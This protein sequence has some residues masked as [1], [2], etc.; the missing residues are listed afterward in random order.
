MH[1]LSVIVRFVYLYYLVKWIYVKNLEM[2]A[3]LEKSQ[4]VHLCTHNSSKITPGDVAAI[5]DAY[6]QISN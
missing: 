6:R 1:L 4:N 5:L 2:I 3:G